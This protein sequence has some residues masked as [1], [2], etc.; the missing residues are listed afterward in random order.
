MRNWKIR[1]SEIE[2]Q[3][4]F[5]KESIDKNEYIDTAIIFDKE[6]IEPKVTYFGS[7]INHSY[8][9]NV[10]LKINKKQFRCDIVAKKFI[11]KNEELKLNY[12]HTP[13]FVKKPEPHFL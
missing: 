3:G 10:I 9:P 7:K 2:G 13:F 11:D 1:K 5:M 8:K 6:T 12:N 4:V